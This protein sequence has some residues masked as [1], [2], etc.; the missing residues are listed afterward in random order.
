M[1]SN[2]AARSL[3]STLLYHRTVW[4]YM[5]ITVPVYTYTAALIM[6]RRNIYVV[7]ARVSDH[8]NMANI[9]SIKSYAGRCN[10]LIF[11]VVRSLSSVNRVHF[12]FIALF[13]IYILQLHPL[14][15]HKSRIIIGSK[16]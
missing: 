13:M 2:I 15:N 6:H 9:C 1:R 5:F 12:T 10:I 7:Y 11:N 8:I 4:I 14:R 3:C 16:L